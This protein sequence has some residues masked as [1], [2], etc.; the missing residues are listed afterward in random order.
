MSIMYAEGQPFTPNSGDQRIVEEQPVSIRLDTR[1]YKNMVLLPTHMS[2]LN[3][4]CILHEWNTKKHGN[5]EML[6]DEFRFEVF[7]QIYDSE[8]DTSLTVIDAQD[9]IIL[10]FRGTSSQANMKTDINVVM[11]PLL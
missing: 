9:R 6:Q 2:M 4:S 8:T 1:S 5:V 7:D 10:S 3:F 11:V